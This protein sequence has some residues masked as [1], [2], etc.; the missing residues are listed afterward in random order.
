MNY[1]MEMNM[2]DNQDQY[3]CRSTTLFRTGKSR[4]DGENEPRTERKTNTKYI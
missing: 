4:S 3:K 2:S 1:S